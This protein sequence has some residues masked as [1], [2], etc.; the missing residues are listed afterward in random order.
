MATMQD[1]VDRG[2]KPLNDAAKT[3]SRSDLLRFANDFV[4]LARRERPDLFFG[5]FAALPGRSRHR[6]QLPL[7]AEFEGPA[8][9]YVTGRAEALGNEDELEQRAIVFLKSAA[10]GLGGG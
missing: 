8:A 10:S 5:Q 7:P 9:D 1:I 2:R 6:R 4:Q 3:G